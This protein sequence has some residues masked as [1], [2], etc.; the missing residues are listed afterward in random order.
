MSL[1]LL[2]SHT[3]IHDD[4]IFPTTIFKHLICGC[5]QYTCKHV[6]DKQ[7]EIIHKTFHSPELISSTIIELPSSSRFEFLI[8][9][10]GSSRPWGF[11]QPSIQKWGKN[12]I[13]L[14]TISAS[15]MLCPLNCSPWP[16][17]LNTPGK[18][19]RPVV[20]LERC[21]KTMWDISWLLNTYGHDA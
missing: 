7:L 12:W 18:N 14:R 6:I 2:H 4:S 3:Y 13:D 19:L 20:Q 9:L 8:T 17:E 5:Y 10:M 11:S 21:N 15:H 16:V 1:E